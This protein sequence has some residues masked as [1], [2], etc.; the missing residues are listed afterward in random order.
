M[1]LFTLAGMMIASRFMTRPSHRDG[2]LPARMLDEMFGFALDNGVRLLF[3]DCRPHLINTYL[4]LGFRNYAKTYNDPIAGMLA[5]L[6]RRPGRA[7]IFFG[8]AIATSLLGTGIAPTLPL[9]AIAIPAF[10]YLPKLYDWR[11]R[12]KLEKMDRVISK[13]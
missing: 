7:G 10:A 4:R 3:C 13:A 5:A 8:L 12:S 11:I 6:G 1:L 9:L 2:D